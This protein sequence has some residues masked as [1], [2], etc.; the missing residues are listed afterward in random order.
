MPISLR[1]ERPHHHLVPLPCLI[2]LQCPLPALSTL[3]FH[4]S[5]LKRKPTRM[6]TLFCLRW[7]KMVIFPQGKKKNEPTGEYKEKFTSNGTPTAFNTENRKCLKAW[8][9]KGSPTSE[10][11]HVSNSLL[12]RRVPVIRRRSEKVLFAHSVLSPRRITLIESLENPT[13]PFDSLLSQVGNTQIEITNASLRFPSTSPPP[14]SYHLN[15]HV[16]LRNPWTL[17]IKSLSYL[18]C[19]LL[20]REKELFFFFNNS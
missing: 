5:P 6:R 13:P 17:K 15:S 1:V 20:V 7:P 9:R 12:L 4:R 8:E 14:F 18:S 3:C 16:F 11:A 2:F 19:L 10:K